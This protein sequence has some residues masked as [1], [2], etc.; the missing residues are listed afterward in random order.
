MRVEACLS[1]S[2]F[3]ALRARDLADAVAVVFDVLRATST[4]V[5]ALGHGAKA[6]IPVETIG[7][8]LAARRR[9]PSVLLAGERN[10]LP[11]GAD[12]A[13]GVAFDLG[14][15]P[16][17]F[18]AERVAG[19]TI[20]S[21]T[22]N[23]TRAL[24][25]SAGARGVLAASFLNLEATARWISGSGAERVVLVCAGTFDETALEDVLGAGS[26]VE[27]LRAGSLGDS[28]RIALEVWR[29]LGGDLE[30][31]LASST[32]G[33]K[34]LSIPELAADVA[35]CARLDSI[36][37]VAATDRAGALRQEPFGVGQV[38]MPSKL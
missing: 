29:R 18:T 32:N 36:P 9:D 8:A 21:T 34:I 15:S 5:T 37:I 26:L 28:A 10:G 27:R 12:L 31:A 33:A 24:R 7:D 35:F 20:V 17:E 23:G 2:D 25:A 38:E 11:I 4:F 13:G 22:T 3:E 19:R 16:R 14:N 30:A 1:P 6:V